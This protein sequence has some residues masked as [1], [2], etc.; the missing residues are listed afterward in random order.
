MTPQEQQLEAY[1][2]QLKAMGLTDEMIAAYKN[3]IQASMDAAANWNQNI[4]QFAAGM[5]Q[6]NALF[7]NDGDGEEDGD[8]EDAPAINLAEPS[9]LSRAEQWAVA[10][11]ADL[12]MLNRQVL[13]D[14]PTGLGKKSCRQL[15]SQWWDIDG[16]EEMVETIGRLQ[17]T[18]HRGQFSIIA[19]AYTILDAKEGKKYLREDLAGVMDEEVA[20]ARLRNLRDALEQFAEDGLIGGTGGVPD[21]AVWDFARIINISRA[22]FDAGYL[23]RDEALAA[24]MDAAA[25][26]RAAYG[27]WRELSVAYQFARYVWNGD[28]EYARMKA[29]MEL[30]L[31]DPASPWVTLPWA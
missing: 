13:N 31:S 27:S 20:V 11:G 16:R 2:K 29:N 23:R 7:S 1:L 30:L 22:G 21:M 25:K 26:I 6:F 5:Q 28:A 19:Q 15:L 9:P 4:A 17:K 8:G 18:G 12:C 14:L 3:Q 10:C 24:I